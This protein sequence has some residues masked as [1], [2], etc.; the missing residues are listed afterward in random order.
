MVE[1]FV[2][3]KT[4][5][6]YEFRW[7]PVWVRVFNLPLGMMCWEAGEAVGGFMGETLEV[8]GGPDGM[9]VGSYLRIMV[10]MDIQEPLM[11]SFTREEDEEEKKRRLHGKGNKAKVDLWCRFEYEFFA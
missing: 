1:D 5:S 2:P 8:D 3:T 11:R 6:E 7:I 9:A 4:L 10:K